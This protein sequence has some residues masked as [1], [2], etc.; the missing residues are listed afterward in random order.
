[1]MK[2]VE[3]ET[4]IEVHKGNIITDYLG[5]HWILHGW[6]EPDYFDI[7]GTVYVKKGEDDIPKAFE[8]RE[9]KLIFKRGKT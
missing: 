9:L 8:P 6:D 5:G 7:L 4:G 3:R 2:L 1:M